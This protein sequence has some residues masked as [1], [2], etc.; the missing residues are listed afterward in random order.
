MLRTRS[1]SLSKVNFAFFSSRERL[2]AA[3]PV[4]DGEEDEVTLSQF[5]VKLFVMETG[6]KERGVGNLKVNVHKTCIKEKHDGSPDPGSFR[7]PKKNEGDESNSVIAARLIMRQENTHKV[8]LNTPVIK[9]LDFVEKP[10]N[11]GTGKQYMFT[12]F[13]GGS[14]KNMLLKVCHFV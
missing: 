9:A 1:S 2:T 7:A 12:A 5:R 6:W 11:T 10:S 3:V 13:D 14:P 4:H 8:I